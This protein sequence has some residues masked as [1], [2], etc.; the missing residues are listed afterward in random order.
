MISSVY[1]LREG[2][3]HFTSQVSDYF[4]A[5]TLHKEFMRLLHS[6]HELKDSQIVQH[7]QQKVGDCQPEA[8]VRADILF[9]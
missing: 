5:S 6:R 4:A 2:L 1:A 7:K 8:V 3:A 9:T